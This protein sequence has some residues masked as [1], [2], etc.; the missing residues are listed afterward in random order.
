LIVSAG[1]NQTITFV[2]IVSLSGTASSTAG[3]PIVSTVWQQLSGPN[4]VTINNPNVLNTYWSGVNTGTYVFQLC[5]TD[6]LGN[7][8]QA[9]VTFTVNVPANVAPISNPGMDQIVI[10][11]TT[12]AA[13]NGSASSDP[14][15]SIATYA[16]T[17]VSGPTTAAF[18]NAAAAY[19]NVSGLA[20]GTYQFQL[21]VTDNRGCSSSCTTLV[22]VIDDP[23]DSVPC[24]STLM[25]PVNGTITPSYNLVSLQW[26]AAT[27]ATSYDV[28]LKLDS[29]GSYTLIGNTTDTNFTTAPL[30][31]NSVYDWYVVPKNAAGSATGCDACFFQFVTPVQ[32]SGTTCTRQRWQVYNTATILGG[33]LDIYDGCNETCYQ[34][35]SMSYWQSTENYP[36]ASPNNS[37][38]WGEL[39]GQPIRH[40]KFPDSLVTHIHDNQNGTPNYNQS[41]IVYVMGVKV[42]H[43][44]VVSAIAAA[45][46]G[47]LITQADANRI[48][49]YRIV[50]GNRFDNKSIV[51]KGLIFD[52]NNYQRKSGGTYF[53]QQPVYF[54]NYPFND[55]N[56]NPFITDNFDNYKKHN[57]PVGPNLPFTFCNRYTFH[58]PDT[59]FSEP[60]AGTVLKLETVEYG[61]AEG[62]YNISDKQAKQRFLSDASYAIAFTGGVVAA[63]LQITPQTKKEYT[64]K[65]S[66][67]SALGIA[68][69]EL[70][71]WLPYQG[72]EGAVIVPES[73]IDTSLNLPYAASIN[74]ATEVT[75]Q[76]IQGKASDFV[77]PLWLVEH[78]PYLLPVYPF[79]LANF[80]TSF[81]NTVLS[82][83]NI[84]LDLIKSLTP[85]RDWT[86]QYQGIGK[87]N[88]YT[89]V[90]NDTGN[91]IRRIDSYSYLSPDNTFINEP[92]QTD[93]T[94]NVAIKYNNWD[95]ESSLYLRYAGAIVPNAGVSSGI[96]DTSRQTLGSSL[97]HCTLNQNQYSNI[98]A[99]YASMKNYVP[100]Q[101]GTIYNI[102]YLPTDSCTFAIGT[103]DSVC[104]GV[105]GGDTFITR[106]ALKI[107]VPYFLANTFDLPQGTD[108]AYDLYPNLSIP[109]NYY[110]NTTGAGTGFTS[111]GD[112]L[113]VFTPTGMATLLGR[114]K[115]I[116]DCS[117]DTFF[118]QN[119]YIYVFHYG[120]P[121]FLVESDYNVDYRYGTN[122]QEG[123]FYPNQQ[124]LN[125]WLQEENVPIAEDN[126]YNYNKTYSKQ[127]EEASFAID[128]PDF[129]PGRECDVEFP[130]RIIY[131][132]GG[133]WLVYSADDF[134]D[135]PLDKGA[136]VSIEG[137]ENQTV[138][139]RNTNSTSIFKSILRTPVEGQTVQIGN[140]GV[141]DNPPQ[142]FGQTTLGYIGTQHKAILHTEFGHIW[143]DAKRGQI[144]NVGSGA[145]SL[146]E[147]SKN[148]MKNWFKENLPFRLLR[149]FPN[150]PE[151]DIDNAYLGV[152][153]TMSFD[154]RF[155]RFLI[156][157]LDWSSTNPALVYNN[158]TK[159]FSI[160]IGETTTIVNLGDPKYFKDCSWTA[161]Y[162]FFTKSWVSF[163]SYK[164]NYYID[165]I[166]FYGSGVNNAT[167]SGYWAHDLYNGS[168][169]VFYGKLYPFI[170]EPV[171]KF[172]QQLNQLNAIEFD[173]EVRRYNNEFDYAI[174]RTIPGF[175]KAIVYND[176][177]N[178]GL[179][180][181]VQ[182]DPNDFTQT[183]KYPKKS[184]DN[185][186]IKVSPANYKWRFN[187]FFALNK[188]ST[189]VPMWK[190]TGNNEEK[191]LNGV[192][193]NYMQSDY[194][195]ARLKGQWFKGRY[196]NDA[197]SNYKILF[198]FSLQNQTVQFK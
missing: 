56:A 142:D 170:V 115:S 43:T 127:N 140:G 48:V 19:T 117:T 60:T 58:S 54:S 141:F 99:Y 161:S 131:S 79:M 32:G 53:D 118:Y 157:K 130:N 21:V 138:L 23:C 143:A 124:D 195:L 34:Y 24:C 28:Y 126:T 98:S 67:I 172:D 162:N 179:L 30:T 39:C 148:G 80:L 69:G 155:N 147:I 82:E 15:G 100:D 183:G 106:F 163:H 145:G 90:A 114:P 137:I 92:S 38:V 81:L 132:N 149:S 101:Y 55:L 192:A 122:N 62:Y 104:R 96:T 68:A 10:L 186:Q 51:G 29:A 109:R 83:A 41:N 159:Q 158:E 70:G 77:N 105:Y 16:W 25:Y 33:N 197:L 12:T 11:P 18:D 47:G 65:G 107:K 9:Q 190:Y 87:Y 95:R 169:Q 37:L 151:T 182:V 113:S 171:F 167:Q 125:Y 189:E 63:L 31:P 71:P 178:S 42:D 187:Q 20:L 76:T 2:G 22:Y 184:G 175:N 1:A 191:F 112:L 86:V 46:S 4:A 116:R 27:C 194:N 177:Y 166:D 88:A 123:D 168:F 93:P 176:W 3:T 102:Q 26:G 121:Y 8:Q 13:L 134:F 174:K 193:F 73:V 180:N 84:I 181:L 196:I 135:Y 133:N 44:S 146:D 14:D 5:V 72:G 97:F 150:M 119:G 111:I 91:K 108:F 154:K 50:R 136:I 156:T 75:T 57:D 74:G 45:V 7:I 160:T 36:S 78:A 64:V 152:G 144:F 128:P 188:A 40:H 120:I 185:W 49:A 52:V 164:P 61:Q 165:F 129:I 85:F 66:V 103:S 35:G 198:K 59:H 89:T 173:T 6:S 94:Q 17:Q 139:V 110:D 153:I